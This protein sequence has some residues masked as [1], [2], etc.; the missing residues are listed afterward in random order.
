[1]PILSGL[2]NTTA[3]PVTLFTHV[4]VFGFKELSFA[5]FITF[6][7]RCTTEGICAIVIVIDKIALGACEFEVGTILTHYS[8]LSSSVRRKASV[9]ISKCGDLV[10]FREIRLPHGVKNMYKS[11]ALRPFLVVVF[12]G[13]CTLG[14][15]PYKRS[16]SCLFNVSVKL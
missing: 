12:V 14:S 13:G 2:H 3:V 4:H 15:V 16:V 10:P 5:Y 11:R 6:F 1:M 8:E 7:E 9:I